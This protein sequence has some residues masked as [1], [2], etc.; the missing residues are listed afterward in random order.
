MPAMHLIGAKAL[1]DFVAAHPEAGPDLGA[2][3]ARLALGGWADAAA[4]A[5]ALGEGASMDGREVA[6]TMP[7]CGVRVR[8]VYDAAAEILAILEVLR[9]QTDGKGKDR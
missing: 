7:W 3:A 2:L 5:A 1:S 9:V 8:L 4:L 6:L